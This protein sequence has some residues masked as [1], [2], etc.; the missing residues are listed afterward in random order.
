MVGPIVGQLLNLRGA[1]KGQTEPFIIPL[2]C[3]SPYSAIIADGWWEKMLRI[4]KKK[5]QFAEKQ[6]ESRAA[7]HQSKQ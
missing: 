1:T 5:T 3:R 7:A 4:R 6:T 2:E